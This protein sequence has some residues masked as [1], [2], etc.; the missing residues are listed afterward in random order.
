MNNSVTGEGGPIDVAIV[1]A[2][3]AGL[4]AA[5]E[6]R[7]QGVPRVVVFDREA[8]AGGI[9]RHCAHLPFGMREFTRVLTGP[10]YAAKL[11]K[12]ALEVSVELLSSVNVVEVRPGGSLYIT[13]DE[14]PEE[15]TARRVIIATGV[16]ESSR[17]AR[18]ISGMRPAG[19]VNTGALQ[20]M[21][22]LKKQKPFQRPVIIGT[23]LVSFSAIHTCRH[24]NISPVA[25]IGE[26]GQ[27]TARWPVEYYARLRGV[28]LYLG[29]RLT[30]IIGDKMVSA[31]E[32]EDQSGARRVVECDGVI[33]S[34]HFTPE[35]P[36]ARN[37]HL[38]V[39]PATNG[40]LVDQFGRCSDPTYFATGNLLRPVETAGW[41]WNEGRQAGRWV[42]DDLKGKLP[43]IKGTKRF[44]TT[45]PL[46]RYILP[47]QINL[48]YDPAS[49]MRYLQLRF[50]R[51]T[52]GELVALSANKVVYRKTMSVRPERR[53]L[54]PIDQ[55]MVEGEDACV[56]LIFEENGRQREM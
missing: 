19:I 51:R 33:L 44:V 47:Q 10:K 43:A 13:S 9:P 2:G 26:A 49:G 12:T 37:G 14:G 35:A 40:P 31:V 20:S 8:Q 56:E 1:G 29:Y 53:V 30:R 38:S 16:R 34:G 6:L 17:S 3:P 48:P 24:A 28:P 45:S 41:S 54:V 15:I 18:L 21:V 23:E 25:M 50:S 55:L 32:I 42:A 7:R 52:R 11:V 5:T 22:Y 36:L 27:V 4:A 39:D 46:I